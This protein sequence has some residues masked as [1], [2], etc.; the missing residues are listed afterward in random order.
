M[1]SQFSFGFCGF[2]LCCVGEMG[3]VCVYLVVP[4]GKGEENES[5]CFSLD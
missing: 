5:F 2:L 3:C 4:G 1:A